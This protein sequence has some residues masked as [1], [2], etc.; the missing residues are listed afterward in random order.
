MAGYDSERGK[1]DHRHLGNVEEPYA[2]TTIA[3]LLDDFEADVMA[4]RGETG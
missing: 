1:G 4:L 3:R 2:F